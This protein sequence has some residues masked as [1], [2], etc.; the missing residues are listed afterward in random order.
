LRDNATALTVVAAALG[1]VLYV[2]LTWIATWVYEPAGVRPSEAGLGYGPMLLGTAVTLF[3]ALAVVLAGVSVAFGA[4]WLRRKNAW[5]YALATI[6]LLGIVFVSWSID[7]VAGFFLAAL[8]MALVIAHLWPEHAYK[9]IAIFGTILVLVVSGVSLWNSAT[10]ARQDIQ[11]VASGAP[12]GLSN[13]WEGQ[14]ALVHAINS[15]KATA[16]CGLYLGQAN[17]IG[18]F[19]FV[20]GDE[21][22]KPLHTLRFPLSSA[23]IEILPNQVVC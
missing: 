21:P 18:V 3:V 6:A 23:L 14:I 12:I 8:P 16:R 22:G 19:V 1:G 5:A 2:L 9:M 7:D 13:P 11:H 17:G 15:K 4:T 20:A 10:L